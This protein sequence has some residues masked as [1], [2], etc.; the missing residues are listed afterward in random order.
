MLLGGGACPK[1][2][3]LSKKHGHCVRN[4]RMRVTNVKALRRALRRAHGFEKIARR[5]CR[6]TPR[7]KKAK[8]K[9]FARR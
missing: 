8:R 3:H 7:F 5:V 2:H 9:G 6:I 4:R 1:G